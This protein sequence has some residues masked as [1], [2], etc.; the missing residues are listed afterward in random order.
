MDRVIKHVMNFLAASR[1]VSTD[2]EDLLT[3]QLIAISDFLYLI[4]K[5]KLTTR[6]QTARDGSD[7]ASSE[8]DSY[9][10]EEQIF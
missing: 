7:E 4:S 10:D 9:D 6:G 8:N 3:K 1:E 2:F 5:E